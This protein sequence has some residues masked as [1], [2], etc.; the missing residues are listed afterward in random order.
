M[1]RAL[2]IDDDQLVTHAM[3]RALHPYYP[4][5]KAVSKGTEAIHEIS[6]CPYHICFLDINSYGTN[7]LQLLKKIKEISPDIKIVIMSGVPIDD[8]MKREIEEWCFHVLTKPFE[9]A[10]LK[11][12]A[13]RALGRIEE[14][15]YA[16]IRRSNRK[17]L[18]KTIDYAITVFDL[19][20]PIRLSLK[21]DV[22]DISDLGVGL[23]THY[24]L[25][26][27][28]LLTFTSDLENADQK[29]GVVKWSK[30]HDAS[31]MYRVGIEFMRAAQSFP[32]GTG[33]L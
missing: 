8:T 19:G 9:I 22:V 5:I 23:R 28:H 26:P 17:P 20:K 30:I 14:E 13:K 16:V 27:G 15:T 33:E 18:K 11:A 12:V 24:P 31:S 7:C 21:G 32:H 6:S 25:E 3:S 10:E 2:V 1:E 29:A 4:E